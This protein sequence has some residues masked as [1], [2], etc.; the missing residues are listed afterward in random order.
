M[1]TLSFPTSYTGLVGLRNLGLTCYMNAA[2]QALSNSMPLA[3]FM[4]ECPAFLRTDRKTP[5]LARPFQRLMLEMWHRKR[6]S[7]V[8]PSV[9]YHGFKQVHTGTLASVWVGLGSFFFFFIV[10]FSSHLRFLLLLLLF[11]LLPIIVAFFSSKSSSSSSL[12]SSL[13]FHFL[14]SLFSHLLHLSL[15]LFIVLYVCSCFIFFFLLVSPS[16]YLRHLLVSF[17]SFFV[18]LFFFSSPS[19]SPDSLSLFCD[20]AYYYF[21]IYPF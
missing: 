18:L 19:S 15:P 14:L 17:L 1:S 12:S 2:L 11:S 20:Y 7:F 3:H 8:T 13:F 10:F 4:I 6:P 21:I 16:F 9:L 5:G